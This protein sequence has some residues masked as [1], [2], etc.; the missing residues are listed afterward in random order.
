MWIWLKVGQENLDH[1]PYTVRPLFNNFCL[2]KI[3][4]PLVNSWSEELIV[5]R[6]STLDE[7]LQNQTKDQSSQCKV[8]NKIPLLR[9]LWKKLFLLEQNVLFIWKSRMHS[10]IWKSWGRQG[11]YNILFLCNT[12]LYN[13]NL[14]VYFYI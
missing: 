13:V 5:C 7:S 8:I 12:I 1:C 6:K 11:P 4:S 3:S 10:N 9:K 2:G 14:S